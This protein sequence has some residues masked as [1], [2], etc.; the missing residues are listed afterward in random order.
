M[1][2]LE[3]LTK[4]DLQ[5]QYKLSMAFI[6]RHAVD[7]GGIGKPLVFDRE[8][9]ELFLRDCMTVKMRR[10]ALSSAGVADLKRYIEQKVEHTRHRIIGDGVGEILGNGGRA[11][12]RQA[13]DERKRGAVA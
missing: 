9:V 4:N 10:D 2:T 1:K 13:Q 11:A 3:M 12:L 6:K 7:M 8:L 5:T